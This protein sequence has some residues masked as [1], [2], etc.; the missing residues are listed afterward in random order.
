MLASWVPCKG[1]RYGSLAVDCSGFGARVG[2]E[3]AKNMRAYRGKSVANRGASKERARKKLRAP[4]RPNVRA[5]VEAMRSR[6]RNGARLEGQ[7][8]EIGFASRGVSPMN[9]WRGR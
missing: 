1:L 7:R 4:A 2:G 6:A 3:C 9:S 5:P 8:C